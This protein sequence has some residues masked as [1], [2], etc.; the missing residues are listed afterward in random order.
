MPVELKIVRKKGFE[1]NPNDEVVNNIFRALEVNYGH[2]PTIK[3]DREGHDYCPCSAYLQHDTCYCGLYVR[4][5]N[6]NE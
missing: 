3:A 1:I 6:S 4:K 2:C 5:N